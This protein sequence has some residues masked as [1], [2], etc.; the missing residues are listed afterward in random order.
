MADNVNDS[1]KQQNAHGIKKPQRKEAYTID[2]GNGEKSSLQ[3]S[4]LKFKKAKQDYD[5]STAK[6]MKKKEIAKQK[7]VRRARRRR[8]KNPKFQEELRQKFINQ[9]KKYFGIP[10][11]RKYWSKDTDEYSSK[12]FL[13]CCGLVRQVVRDL[14]KDFG[15][16]IGPWNQAYMFDTLPH[17][18]ESEKDMKPGDLVFMS[19]TYTNP[20]STNQKHFMTHV[21]IWL[22]H[23]PKTIGARWNNG[24]VQIWD[25]YKFEAKSFSN[26]VY[27][28][29]SIDTWLKGI[30]KSYC[31]EH[32][33]K[34]SK[35]KP[36][37]KSIFKEAQKK[38]KEGTDDQQAS[39]QAGQQVD[40]GA[41]E[42][43]N[44]PDDDP[45]EGDDEGEEDQVEDDEDE[46]DLEDDLDEGEDNDEEVNEDDEAADAFDQEQT[47][48]V[49]PVA[50]QSTQEKDYSQ[51]SIESCKKSPSRKSPQGVDKSKSQGLDL[52]QSET[53]LLNEIQV[54]KQNEEKK[55]FIIEQKNGDEKKDF[56]PEL[57]N[58][59]SMKAGCDSKDSSLIEK[60]N[61]GQKHFSNG[62]QHGGCGK[63]KSPHIEKNNSRNNDSL[64]VARP[65]SDSCIGSASNSS[66]ETNE[67]AT[68]SNVKEAEEKAHIKRGKKS[69]GTRQ[70]KLPQCSLPSNMQPT[71]YIG[72]GNGV[73]LVEGPLVALGWKRTTDKYDERYRLKWV[74]CKTRINYGGFKEGDQLVNHIPNGQLLTNKLGLLNSLQE[75]ER[76][77]LSTKGRPPRLKFNDFFPETYR[78]DEK[79]NKDIFLEVYQDGEMWICKPTGLNQGKGIFIIRSRDEINKTLEE[80]EQKKE[81]LSRS[82]KPLMSRIVQ[83]YIMNPLLLAARKFDV[84]AYMLIASTVPF[85][86]LYHKGYV[87]LCCAKYDNDDSNLSIHLTN[88]FV[89]KKDPNFKDIKED[90]VWSME[91]FN[92]YFNEK[93]AAKSGVEPDWVKNIL[94]KQMQKIMIHCFNSVKHKL[95]QRIGYFDLFGLDFMVDADLKVW[96]I[97]INVNPSLAVTCGAQK[98][99]VPGVVE[100]SLYLAIECF[101]KTKKNQPLLPLNTLKNMSVLYCGTR[102]NTIPPRAA[103]SVSPVTNERL[104]VTASSATTATSKTNRHANETSRSGH[105]LSVSST[106]LASTSGKKSEDSSSNAVSKSVD[107]TSKGTTSEQPL[108][109]SETVPLKMTHVSS[110]EAIGAKNGS[111]NQVSDSDGSKEPKS[112]WTLNSD[113]VLTL[114]APKPV[115]QPVSTAPNLDQIKSILAQVGTTSTASTTTGTNTTNAGSAANVKS[116]KRN[117]SVLSPLNDKSA[118][119]A[120]IA[121]SNETA[122]T[123]KSADTSSEKSN[124]APPRSEFPSLLAKVDNV[125]SSTVTMGL[126]TPA[127]VASAVPLS[128]GASSTANSSNAPRSVPITTFSM[129]SVVSGHTSVQHERDR[130]ETMA[131]YTTLTKLNNTSNLPSISHTNSVVKSTLSSGNQ[132]VRLSN[133]YKTTTNYDA[134]SLKFTSVGQSKQSNDSQI[135]VVPHR[136]SKGEAHVEVIPHRKHKDMF[137]RGS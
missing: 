76:V 81:Q 113:G 104:K 34:R 70:T 33:W 127:K 121:S 96:L 67:P 53:S 47:T 18:I 7:R 2:F 40:Q 69:P 60:K 6:M 59:D 31:P 74:E 5:N 64:E 89:Q 132:N 105:R 48:Q 133:V 84:R 1:N 108:S 66:K 62:F 9:A 120:S 35:F 56:S 21:E 65:L 22:G 75:Y 99:V 46:E 83:R 55:D 4:F 24:K 26:T 88:Q 72:G 114:Q 23:G 103:R 122:T 38:E 124:I 16:V 3:D 115:I 123:A 27:H 85:L 39:D 112:V 14:A 94:T 102:A 106:P 42:V 25:H 57:K 119:N 28:F 30:C 79:N 44:E 41:D 137:D 37:K 130:A 63:Q 61:D 13:D 93:I 131:A 98:E 71:F 68:E 136:Q 90:T 73:S 43:V 52:Q 15:F 54:E 12:L 128:S 19:G 92:D 20:K 45:D 111:I 82:T 58:G 109:E 32:K 107:N 11:A 100:E 101:E 135:E 125:K 8:Q 77:T 91:K 80:R 29:R 10:Y 36:G 118:V 17:I 110:A 116:D 134:P 129:S 51:N 86:V 117:V 78:L 50:S 126:S 49:S 87:R 97:E 95:N